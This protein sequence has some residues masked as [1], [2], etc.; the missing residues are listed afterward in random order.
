MKTIL[1]ATDFS[2]AAVNA[3]EYA[4][5][6]AIE[7]EAQ[8]LL[9]HVYPVPVIYGEVPVSVN[10]DEVKDNAEF[11]INEQKVHLAE[12]TNG[13]VIINTEV[14]MGAFYQELERFCG[15]IDPYVVVMGNH[16]SST[17]ERILFGNHAVYATKHLAW[18][19][20]TVP[21]GVG[22]SAIKKIG[23]ACDFN[24]VVDTMPIDEVKLLVHDFNAALHVLNTGKKKDFDP[25][26]V[27]ESGL[28]QEMLLSINP[29]YHFITSENTDEGIL[30]FTEKNKIDLLIVLPK[31]HGLMDQLLHKSHTKELVLHSHVPVMSLHQ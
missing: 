24:K 28:L 5:K 8:I 18:P 4:A 13:K 29:V 30:E 3:A 26:I 25:E 1:V 15:R 6:L 22:Y 23:L 17:T 9:L 31:R 11:D 21:S 19:L 7:I 14:R 16:S 2:S 20:I 10:A 12:I 27:F